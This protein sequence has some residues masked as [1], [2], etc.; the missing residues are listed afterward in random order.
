MTAM[1]TALR[2]FIRKSLEVSITMIRIFKDRLGLPEGTLQ[3]LHSD[4][5][6]SLSAVHIP[7][8][9]KQP[10]VSQNKP[11]LGKHPDFASLV[12]P[13]CFWSFSIR[14][15]FVSPFCKT[16]SADFKSYLLANQSGCMWSYALL[17][18]PISAGRYSHMMD[19]CIQLLPGHTIRNIG[20][21]LAIFSGGI[22][23]SDMHR[24]VRASG[25][26]G[27]HERF[28]V[29]FF[30]RPDNS[31]VLRVFVLEDS[32]LITDAVCAKAPRSW[33]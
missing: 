26:Q 18:A 6:L 13:N 24:A 11:M 4:E 2:P 23:Q 28:S 8:M 15:H 27:E 20:D 17:D 25:D 22:V 16:G 33:L 10:I 7:P 31:R 29:V 21:T 14:R 5:E 30:T 3:R 32:S 19:K 9:P 12:S 1:P